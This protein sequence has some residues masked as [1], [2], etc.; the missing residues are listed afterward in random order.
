MYIYIYTYRNIIF[1]EF[2][3]GQTTDLPNPRNRGMSAAKR[4]SD[5]ETGGLLDRWICLQDFPFCDCYGFVP[6]L[7]ARLNR[8]ALGILILLL[9]LF[10]LALLLLLL[11]ILT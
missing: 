10:L 11:I 3:A 5:N 7:L 9:F 2:I 1:T 8:G 4:D 6:S